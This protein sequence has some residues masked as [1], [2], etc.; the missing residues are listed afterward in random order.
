MTL[1]AS[2]QIRVFIKLVNSIVTDV[3]HQCKKRDSKEGATL[4]ERPA[5]DK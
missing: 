3:Q 1:N 5:E 4:T 2:L